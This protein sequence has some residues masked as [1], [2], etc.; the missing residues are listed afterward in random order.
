MINL[1]QFRMIVG[2]FAFGTLWIVSDLADDDEDSANLASAT[3]A[4]VTRLQDN[5]EDPS[6]GPTLAASVSNR[7]IARERNVAWGEPMID[8]VS[9]DVEIG[10]YEPEPFVV[11]PNA[12]AI[13][14]SAG[15]DPDVPVP[16]K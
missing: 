4:A 11:P 16:H 9:P 6:P 7:G 3:D 8:P 5:V 15:A 2:I 12:S 13:S 10:I 14:D 1:S